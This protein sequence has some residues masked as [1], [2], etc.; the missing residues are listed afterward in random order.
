MRS[1]LCSASLRSLSLQK[2]QHWGIMMYMALRSMC[3]L[4]FVIVLCLHG[5][6]SYFVD[7]LAGT[8]RSTDA[9]PEYHPNS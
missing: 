1:H 4:S 9:H 6:C 3:R 2:L 5:V 7:V 8:G